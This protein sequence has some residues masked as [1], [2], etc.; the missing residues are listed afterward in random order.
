MDN[1]GKNKILAKTMKNENW[2]LNIKVEF[3]VH[4][5]LQQSSLP[6]VTIMKVMKHVRAMMHCANL[7][8]EIW[9]LVQHMGMK[10]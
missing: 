1:A 6:E 5:M 8:I 3:A 2:H 4:N 9:Y 7:P 10:L